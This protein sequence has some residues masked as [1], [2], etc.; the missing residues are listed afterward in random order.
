MLF[1][2]FVNI[3]YHIEELSYIPSELKDFIIDWY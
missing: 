3:L 1:V 2:G